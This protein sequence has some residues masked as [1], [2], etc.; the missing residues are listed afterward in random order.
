MPE[1]CCLLTHDAITLEQ[2]AL[3]EP[4]T[5]GVYS[6]QQA[7]LPKKADVAILGAGPIGLSCMVSAK[8]AGVRACYMTEKV[9]QRVQTARANGATWVGNPL[10]EDVVAGILKQCPLGV[11]VVF[12]CA[13]QQQTIDQ[14]L[15][16]LEPGGKLV[17]VGIPREERVSLSLDRARRK[18]I[19]IVNIRRQN[20]C[21]K[22]AIDL[23]VSGKVNVDFM[24]THRFTLDQTNEAFDLVDLAEAVGCDDE[25][26][27][28]RGIVEPVNIFIQPENLP[29]D[30]II[31]LVEL[32]V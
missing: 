27:E 32:Q 7:K 3:C 15:D 18:E 30:V 19:T 25:L 31:I 20:G 21:T 26:A 12:E 8:A 1:E 16:L 22:K 6:V 11:D 24:V 29:V 17:L 28:V 10:E 13:G 9:P 14:G 4:L 5:I 23:I 2:G